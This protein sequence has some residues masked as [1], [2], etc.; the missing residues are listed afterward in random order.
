MHVLLNAAH[1]ACA[2]VATV[3]FDEASTAN[4]KPRVAA[5]CVW[6]S[7][8]LLFDLLAELCFLLLEVS[9]LLL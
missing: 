6:L 3:P 9:I 5:H 1:T 8:R 7:A 2:H 4:Q